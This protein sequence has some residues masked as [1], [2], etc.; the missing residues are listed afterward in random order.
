MTTN[1]DI[2]DYQYILK[3]MESNDGHIETVHKGKR[4]NEWKTRS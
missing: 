2:T 3:V 1:T 4:G